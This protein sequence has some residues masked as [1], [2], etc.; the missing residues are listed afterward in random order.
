MSHYTIDFS[1]ELEENPDKARREAINASIRYAGPGAVKNIFRAIW[2]GQVKDLDHL[3]LLLSIF[4]GIEGYPVRA[5]YE[6]ATGAGKVA[7]N[8]KRHG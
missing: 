6:Y 1:K 8:P 2:A 5:I 3:R 7:P 4:V